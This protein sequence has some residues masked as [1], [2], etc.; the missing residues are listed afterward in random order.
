MAGRMYDSR[1]LCLYEDYFE[2]TGLCFYFQEGSREVREALEKKD[3]LMKKGIFGRDVVCGEVSFLHLP[4]GSF[5]PYLVFSPYIFDKKTG[6]K[7][8][9][10]RREIPLFIFES[11]IDN[12]M[13]FL[14][15]SKQ[16]EH[17]YNPSFGLYLP[18]RFFLE[19]AEQN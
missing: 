19:R 15:N 8:F 18:E 4:R 6:K 13:K 17:Y 2:K 10:S 1:G 11:E 14:V 16:G 9:N 3:L 12:W 7:I 5:R